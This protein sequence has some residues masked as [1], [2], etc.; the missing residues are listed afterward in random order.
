MIQLK[1]DSIPGHDE[2]SSDREGSSTSSYNI[3]QV[4]SWITI[5]HHFLHEAKIQTHPLLERVKFFA[6]FSSNLDTFFMCQVSRFHHHLEEGDNKVNSD[7]LTYTRFL[8]EIY[9]A[10][11][12]LL[13]EQVTIWYD[14][15]IPALREEGIIIHTYDS[16]NE[17]QIRWVRDFFLEE[18]F[19]TLTPL[20]FDKTH[21]FPFISNHA[22]NL[23][24]IVRERNQEEDLFV[25]IKVPNDLFPRLLQIPDEETGNKSQE[26]VDLIFLEDVISANLDLLFPGMKIRAAYPFRVTRDA[27]VST[28]ENIVNEPPISGGESIEK[29]R[30]GIP[31]RIEVSSAM[32][33]IVCGMI[34]DKLIKY[35]HMFY[36]TTGPVGMADLI[37]LLDL[38]RPD[39]KYP[40]FLPNISPDI[41]DKRVIC[42]EVTGTS[43]QNM[44]SDPF[45]RI[46]RLV[47]TVI[48]KI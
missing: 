34:C 28:S 7:N 26:M 1:H 36:R 47:Q 4:L 24:I 37:C 18:I 30:I 22:L 14:E 45:H 38:N 42:S 35:S 19:P 3:S 21:P 41:R 12:P 13:E 16:L 17:R 8:E 15:I 33:R 10:L 2:S 11:F 43:C 20:A 46:W 29:R 9:T 48:K 27:Y 5:Y 39:L 44:R 32:D 40:P 25:R 23:A 6:K 31:V